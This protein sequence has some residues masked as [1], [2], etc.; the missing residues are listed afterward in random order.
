[1]KILQHNAQGA[2]I[3]LDQRELL[4]V[5]ALVQEGRESF[6]CNTESG[7]ALDQLFSSANVLVEEA[8][9]E[10]LKMTMQQQKISTVVCPQPEL[11]QDA[12]NR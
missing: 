5:M 2:T 10:N 3:Q 9:R 4:L 1:M 7:K 8:R 6:K 12:S 11:Q